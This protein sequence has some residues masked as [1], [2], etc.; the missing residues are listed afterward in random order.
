MLIVDFLIKEVESWAAIHIL[1]LYHQGGLSKVHQWYIS[2][3]GHLVEQLGCVKTESF[4]C[5][6]LDGHVLTHNHCDG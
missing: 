1:K 3:C 5:S 4:C 2:S 6:W